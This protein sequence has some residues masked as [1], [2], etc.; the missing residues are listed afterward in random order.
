MKT[1]KL[2]GF[3]RQFL[4]HWQDNDMQLATHKLREKNWNT[5]IAPDYM[6]PMEA[7]WLAEALS[8]QSIT[9]AI[10][11]YVEPT[12]DID[13]SFVNS[14]RDAILEM[15]FTNCYKTIFLTDE[16]ESFIYYKDHSNRFFFIASDASFI[17]SAYKCSLSTRKMMFFD[18]WVN[19]EINNDEEKA[20]LT[21]VWEKYSQTI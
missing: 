6:G 10:G 9:K 20:F 21:K 19:D 8:M 7:E 15:N 1:N 14:N 2:H 11:I 4:H 13:V 17:K 18:H 16:H 12:A 5:A 3:A